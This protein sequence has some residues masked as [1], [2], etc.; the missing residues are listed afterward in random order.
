MIQENFFMKGSIE[1]NGVV[2]NRNI[3]FEGLTHLRTVDNS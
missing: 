3:R 1:L 2:F